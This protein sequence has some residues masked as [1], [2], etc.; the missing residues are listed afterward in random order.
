SSRRTRQR[1]SNSIIW[2]LQSVRSWMPAEFSESR[3]ECLPE[4]LRVDRNEFRAPK[5]AGVYGIGAGASENQDAPANRQRRLPQ[6]DQ[7]RR[8]ASRGGPLNHFDQHDNNEENTDDRREEAGQYEH[9][10]RRF[11]QTPKIKP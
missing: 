8:S 5:S 11:Q 4:V 7:G 6:A 9:A 10:A 1:S 2:P 3:S